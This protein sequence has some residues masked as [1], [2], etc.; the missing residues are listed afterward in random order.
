MFYLRLVFHLIVD[1]N[2]RFIRVPLHSRK[3][4]GADW[5]IIRGNSVYPVKLVGIYRKLSDLVI[6]SGG[7]WFTYKYS[8]FH[9]QFGDGTPRHFKFRSRAEILDVAAHVEAALWKWPGEAKC[10]AVIVLYPPPM[11]ICYLGNRKMDG[12]PYSIIIQG[13]LFMKAAP[14]FDLLKNIE[15]SPAVAARS[16]DLA[17][18]VCSQ[19]AE[20]RMME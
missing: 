15:I 8:G 4:F 12:N 17:D 14:F 18:L 9:S 1:K 6:D 11:R 10:Q 7:D 5:I 20:V 19:V 13:I 2:T 16:Q 3:K